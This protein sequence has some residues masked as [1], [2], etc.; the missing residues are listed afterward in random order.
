MRL[1]SYW[2]GFIFLPQ[3][4]P[5]ATPP[6]AIVCSGVNLDSSCLAGFDYPAQLQAVEA[7][8]LHSPGF[9]C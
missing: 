3:K 5:A 8:F 2:D 4:S 1:F 9:E 7:F 6:V